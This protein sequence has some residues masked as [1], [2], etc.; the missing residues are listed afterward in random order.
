MKTTHAKLQTDVAFKQWCRLH[1]QLLDYTND[2]CVCVC[3]KFS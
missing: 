2:V 1:A 3:L